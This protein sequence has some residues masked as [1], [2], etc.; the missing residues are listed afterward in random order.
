MSK[1]T[2]TPSARVKRA[3]AN[4]AAD[5]GNAPLDAATVKA[6]ERHAEAIKLLVRRAGR[7]IIEIGHRLTKAQ[8]IA[9]HGNWLRWLDQEFNWSE[10]TARNYMR[11]HELASIHNAVVDLDLP[12]RSLY[13]L[14]APSTPEAARQDVIERA[15]SGEDLSHAQ[16]KAAVD[17]AK[18]PKSE[19]QAR[20]AKPVKL[21]AKAVPP[22]EPPPKAK[23]ADPASPVFVL[24]KRL[25]PYAQI[26]CCM[27]LIS[28]MERP[29]LADFDLRYAKYRGAS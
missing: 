7:D 22:S 1:I 29:T 16:V 3:I 4:L 13:L 17:E 12:L 24:F 21:K 9:G 27:K 2:I 8:E 20:P 10:Q 6:L 28:L 25:A 11:V 23:Q 15:A 14:A 26:E 19:A 18:P 5:V